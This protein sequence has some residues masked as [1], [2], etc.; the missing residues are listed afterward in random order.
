[1]TTS[2]EQDRQPQTSRRTVIKGAAWSVPVIM[3]AVAVPQAVASEPTGTL[4]TITVTAS[5]SKEATRT[6]TL[7]ADANNITYQVIGGGGASGWSHVGR[8]PW[9]ANS[10]TEGGSLGGSGALITGTLSAA[11]AGQ[12]LLLVAGGGGSIVHN[13][14][15]TG[16]GNGGGP[17]KPNWVDN[18]R[19]FNVHANWGGGGGAGS[20]ITIAGAPVVVAGGGGGGGVWANSAGSGYA[21][22]YESYAVQPNPQVEGPGGNASGGNGSAVSAT[23]LPGTVVGNPGFGAN[24]GTGGAGGVSGSS[25]FTSLNAAQSVNGAAGGNAGTGNRGGGDGANGATQTMQVNMWPWDPDYNRQGGNYD[26]GGERTYFRTS[27]VSGSGGGGY[28]GGGSGGAYLVNANQLGVQ[29]STGHGY[30]KTVNGVAGN[31]GGGGA[32]SSMVAPVVAGVVNTV[33]TEGTAGNA[34]PEPGGAGGVGKVVLTYYST[35]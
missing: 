10:P 22:P 4:K 33:L 1:M 32:G 19:T 34:S 35:P 15:S 12:T 30:N 26:R 24:D 16:F 14:G 20:A 9:A 6:V 3:A 11:A 28:A 17:A 21:D 13:T 31:A 29:V 18:G 25:T 7:P 8:T 2:N 27:V 23:Y 5:G